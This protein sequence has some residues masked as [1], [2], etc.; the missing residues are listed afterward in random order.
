MTWPRDELKKLLLARWG[1]T[2]NQG[3]QDVVIPVWEID[4]AVE[5]IL[6]VVMTEDDT[7][8]SPPISF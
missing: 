7:P 1:E 8:E 6:E 4:A 2:S 3:D 5:A